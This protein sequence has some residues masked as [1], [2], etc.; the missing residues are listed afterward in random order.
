MSSPEGTCLL[1]FVL[2]LMLK[3]PKSCGVLISSSQGGSRLELCRLIEASDLRTLPGLLGGSLSA[4]QNYLLQGKTEVLGVFFLKNVPDLTFL[5]HCQGWAYG[6]GGSRKRRNEHKEKLQEDRFS[7]RTDTVRESRACF[8]LTAQAVFIL[9]SGEQNLQD[10]Q[11]CQNSLSVKA[12]VHHS[13][14][15]T[16]TPPPHL[17]LISFRNTFPNGRLTLTSL[18]SKR[19]WS[20][21][22]PFLITR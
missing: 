13:L 6:A 2:S 20:S 14:P 3:H 22:S 11:T 8:C 1:A 17:L 9:G 21:P 4:S 5:S 19:P 10:S 7:P 12:S 18:P 16:L 15:S